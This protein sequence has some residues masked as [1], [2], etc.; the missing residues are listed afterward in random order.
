MKFQKCWYFD[1][2]CMKNLQPLANSL[3]DLEIDQCTEITDE[4]LLHV[5]SLSYVVQKSPN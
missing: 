3:V 4:G 5:T 1:N 2:T